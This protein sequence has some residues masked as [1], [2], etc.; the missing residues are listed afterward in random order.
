M[1]DDNW[2]EGKINGQVR[3]FPRSYVGDSSPWARALYDFEPENEGEL[4]FSEGDLITLTDEIDD[5]W[6]EGKVNGQV[7]Y[8]LRNYVEDV[9]PL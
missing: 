8:F 3:Y 5:N 2:L 1:I 4:Q 9:V 7:G 6:L